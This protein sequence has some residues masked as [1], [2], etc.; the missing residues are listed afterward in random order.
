MLSS[1]YSCVPLCNFPCATCVPNQPSTCTSCLYG[2]VFNT[3]SANNCQNN[4]TN[5]NQNMNCSYCGMG[6]SMVVNNTMAYIN[7]TCQA[8][9]PS[10][11]RCL[12]KNLSVCTGCFISSY[13]LNGSC[14]SC[15]AGCLACISQKIC[16]ACSQGYYANLYPTVSYQY[17]NNLAI[18]CS[19]CAS[20]CATCTTSAIS[21][22]TC[23]S[24][25]YLNGYQCISNFNYQINVTFSNS[26]TST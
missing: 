11:S 4:N 9:R 1:N 20:P 13:L 21:C 25:Y 16:Y 14:V 12:P 18:Y 5:C 19:A 17:D 15:P 3:N 26:T 24:G 10:C 2:Y 22:N 6:F 7:Q 8:C 23:V